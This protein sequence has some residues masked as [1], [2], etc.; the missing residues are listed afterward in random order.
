MSQF[1][2]ELSCRSHCVRPEPRTPRLRFPATPDAGHKA[3]RTACR[4]FQSEF[5][6]E[7]LPAPSTESL[8][9]GPDVTRAQLSAS[10]EIAQDFL[11]PRA[12]LCIFLRRYRSRLM[13]QFQPEDSTGLRQGPYVQPIFSTS[14]ILYNESTSSDITSIPAAFQGP[15]KFQRSSEPTRSEV[16]TRHT[17]PALIVYMIMLN[18]RSGPLY[19]KGRSLDCIIESGETLK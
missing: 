7:K 2:K 10:H 17:G 15:I 13:P 19:R 5:P 14:H 12:F 1:A 9:G 8:A 11:R 16:S 3:R 4:Y 18:S 6:Q